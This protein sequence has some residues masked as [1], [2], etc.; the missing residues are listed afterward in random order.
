MVDWSYEGGTPDPFR[1]ISKNIMTPTV[2]GYAKLRKGM[3]WAELSEGTGISRQPIF[4]VTVRSMDDEQSKTNR[5]LS[6]LF[7]SRR[8]AERH[9]EQL[10]ED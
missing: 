10:Q 3:G 8:E 1:G 2:L 7:Q 4:G 5:D 9:I 6:K